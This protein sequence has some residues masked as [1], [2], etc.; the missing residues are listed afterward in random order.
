M[1]LLDWGKTCDQVSQNNS[2]GI[3]YVWMTLQASNKN[4][5]QREHTHP[6]RHTLLMWSSA[7]VQSVKQEMDKSIVVHPHVTARPRS[8]A[9]LTPGASHF[10]ARGKRN[11]VIL[12]VS[13]DRE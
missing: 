9:I 3:T 2:G 5:E 1:F 12:G 6:Q 8:W 10:Q 11:V 4:L 13:F 7:W